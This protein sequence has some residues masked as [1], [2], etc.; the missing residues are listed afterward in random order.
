MFPRAAPTY[1]PACYDAGMA[2]FTFGTGNLRKL[3]AMPL[4]VVGR[5]ATMAIPRRADEWVFGCGTGVGDGALAVWKALPPD[6]RAQATWISRNGADEEAAARLGLRTV[7]RGTA[8]A[9]WRTARSGVVVVTHGFGDVCRYGLHGAYVAQLWHGIP[10]KRIHLDSPATFRLPVLGRTRTSAVLLSWAYRRSTRMI[11]LVPA[12][13]PA[14]ARR[15]ATA[16]DLSPAQLPVT[17]EPRVDVLSSAP[18]ADLRPWGRT[19]IAAALGEP[20]TALPSSV[21]LFA[22]TWRDGEVDP[23]I[24]DDTAW[25]QL[26]DLLTALDAWLVIRPHPL[27]VGDY[28]AAAHHPRVKLLTSDRLADL[29]PALAGSDVLITDYSSAAYDFSLL[30][31]PMVFFAPDLEHY[32]RT[33]TLYAPYQELTGGPWTRTWD[34]VISELQAV[35][36]DE[37]ARA[38][39]EQH[40]RDLDRHWHA[41]RDGKNAARVVQHIMTIRRPATV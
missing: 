26:D 40:S 35:L 1:D 34:E 41:H 6:L 19:A 17:G 31:R 20:V 29:A 22:P 37:E 16:F 23:T 27:S 11:S 2:S 10:F 4:Y 12:A 36:T 9:F 15:L 25:A 32:A 7:R 28:S 39:K 21:V 30:G 8:S 14:A 13:S 3:L 5:L 33:R 24:P 38:A 18:P